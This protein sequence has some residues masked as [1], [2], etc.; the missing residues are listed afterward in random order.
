MAGFL[1][2]VFESGVR[3]IRNSP[4]PSKRR[5]KHLRNNSE[6]PS[7]QLLLR[8]EAMDLSEIVKN[9]QLLVANV[10]VIMILKRF[11]LSHHCTY[12]VYLCFDL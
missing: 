6:A 11:V 5:W 2:I 9:V 7:H 12:L 3:R 1:K 8:K 10:V 4:K